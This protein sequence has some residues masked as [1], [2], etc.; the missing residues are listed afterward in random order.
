MRARDFFRRART[1]LDGPLHGVRVVDA[2]KV[3]SG[4]MTSA[5]LGD[6]GADVVRVELPDRPDGP[7]RPR[8]PGTRL[9]WFRE[10]VH[11]NKRSVGLDLRLDA[12]RE[13]FLRLVATADVVVENYLPGTLDRW[14]VG[15]EA[16]RAARPDIVLVSISGY[17]Q[18]GPDRDRRAYDPAVQAA[19]GLMAL[20]GAPAGPP[21]RAPTFLADD[22]AALH[23]AIGALAALAHRARTG[24]GQHVDVAM[25]DCLLAAASGLPTLAATGAPPQ[26][27]GNETDFVVPANAYA[28]ADGHLYLVAALDRHWRALAEA[29]G[30]PE[31]GA[32]PGFATAAERLANRAAVNAVVADWC[33]VRPLADALAHLVGHGLVVAPV[34]TLTEA[35]A[36]PGVAARGMLAPTLLSDG[37]V[38]P[39]VAP[40]VKFSRTPT[41]IRSAAPVPGADTAEVL[42]ELAGR[43]ATDETN[44]LRRIS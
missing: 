36:D 9:S 10:T 35:V 3:W 29:L 13:Q 42:A 7:A 17:G 18:Y 38:A 31:L 2:T 20:A 37:T 4:P 23:G 32:A 30:R 40:P 33:A 14:G 34:R 12:G 39:L 11:R 24:E 27:H 5:V 16:C 8:I 1:D 41:R 22:V 43:P 44:A 25:A 15:Y 6:L 21:M 19:S 26:R 28:C